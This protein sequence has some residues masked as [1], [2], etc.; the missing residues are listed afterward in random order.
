MGTSTWK[1]STAA[2]WNAAVDDTALTY[3]HTINGKTSLCKFDPN[4]D[5]MLIFK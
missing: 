4:V 3:F 1:A 5:V 2:L